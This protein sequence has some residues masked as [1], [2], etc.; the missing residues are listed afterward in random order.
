[1]A[2]MIHVAPVGSL[3]EMNSRRYRD[4]QSSI[5]VVDT[6][7]CIEVLC[8]HAATMLQVSDQA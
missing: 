1:M 8:V 6:H 4:W 2:A 5:A 3:R 7:Y